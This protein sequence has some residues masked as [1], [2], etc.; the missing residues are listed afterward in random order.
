MIFSSSQ[1]EEALGRAKRLEP[2]SLEDSAALLHFGI[3]GCDYRRALVDAAREVTD[4]VFGEK[5]TIFVP[6]YLSNI[7]RNQ[8]FYCVDRSTNTQQ[9]RARLD[10]GQFVD[11]VREL[12]SRGFTGVEIVSAADPHLFGKDYAE[13]VRVAKQV[14]M[15]SVMA[16][17]ELTDPEDYEMMG[18]AGLDAY[19]L[20]QETY[21]PETYAKFHPAITHKG[22]MRK[23]LQAHDLAAKAGISHFGLGAL[24]GLYDWRYE[25]LSLLDHAK[26][27]REDYGATVSFSIPRV[28]KSPLA[29][30]SFDFETSDGDMELVVA[31]LRLAFPSAGIGVSTRETRE[32]RKRLLSISGTSTSAESS[33][34]VGGYAN[35]FGD[36]GQFPV[37]FISLDDAIEDILSVG[38]MPNFCT[39]CS[40]AN[41]YGSEFERLAI[42]GLRDHCQ[43]NTV[44]SLAEYIRNHVRD[45]DRLWNVLDGYRQRLPESMRER[46]ARQLLELKKGGRNL[47]ID[48]RDAV[49]NLDEPKP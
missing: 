28:Q 5:V 1:F 36:E 14:G 47:F 30:E 44:L 24:F 26:H 29:L 37:H 18:E 45:K 43:A 32:M 27:L 19:I 33:T 13:K 35:H 39:A 25:L 3:N 48:P 42:D 2:L 41:T 17:V 12:V 9:K 15:R 38:K 31:T 10:G 22:D 20:F 11:E 49:K 21:H 7:C 46:V 40:Q 4:R 6:L 16:N 8:C 23:R 34:S